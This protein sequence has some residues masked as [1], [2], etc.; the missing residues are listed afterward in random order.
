MRVLVERGAQKQLALLW[1]RQ[2]CRLPERSGGEV[3]PAGQGTRPQRKT[4]VARSEPRRSPQVLE[5][6]NCPLRLLRDVSSGRG[7]RG[8]RLEREPEAGG[9]RCH[10]RS[11]ECLER[12]SAALAA[13]TAEKRNLA[14][15]ARLVVTQGG[16]QLLRLLQRWG[17][18]L[19][20]SDSLVGG[21]H[22]RVCLLGCGPRGKQPGFRTRSSRGREERRAC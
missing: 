11:P 6:Q 13:R 20:A 10:A 8:A 18:G 12:F 3:P 16:K 7:A 9:V 19:V 21:L 2:Q 17:G 1:A 15:A 4:H 14:G 5:V 22:G